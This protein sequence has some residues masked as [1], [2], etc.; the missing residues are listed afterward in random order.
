[1]PWLQS[2]PMPFPFTLQIQGG[3][4]TRFGNFIAK[5]SPSWEKKVNSCHSRKMAVLNF[6]WRQLSEEGLWLKTKLGR[7]NMS[8]GNLAPSIMKHFGVL[9]E[10]CCVCFCFCFFFT[11]WKKTLLIFQWWWTW[12]HL[13]SSFNLSFAFSLETRSLVKI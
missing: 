13:C 8:T 9:C 10:I 6:T 11:S 7:Y 3:L 1:M 12:C 2:V 5:L 4:G